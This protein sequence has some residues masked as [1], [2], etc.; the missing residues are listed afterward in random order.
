MISREE[1]LARRKSGI[2][3]SDVAAVLGVSHWKTPWQLWRDKTTAEI[4]SETNARLEAGNRLEPVVAQWVADRHPGMKIQVRRRQY[5]HRRHPELIAN[6]DRYIVGGGIL[7]C[8]TYTGYDRDRW[9]E[10]QTDQVPDEYLLQVQHYMHVTGYRETLLGVL[11]HGWDLR[12]YE[13]GYDRELAEFAAAKCVEF[14]HHHVLAG[15][16]PPPAAGDDLAE[17]FTAKAGSAVRATPETVALVERLRLA[18]AET[19]HAGAVAGELTDEL[20]TIM[21]ENE[22]L[23]GPDGKPLATW[24]QSKGKRM[25]VTD[26]ETVAEKC[27]IPPDLI[28]AHTRIVTGRG[29][30]PLLIK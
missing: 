3:G 10:P 28:A 25:A 14:W 13:I 17:Y 23:I 5:R 24:K 18:K 11:I 26:W 9:G 29:N 27:G 16:P 7:E 1:F 22:C 2:G 20:K 19:K 15:V 30:R 21:G 6:L 4:S 8:K 12:E